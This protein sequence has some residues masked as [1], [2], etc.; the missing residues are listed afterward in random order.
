MSIERQSISST[1]V[2][3]ALV[4]EPKK[5]EDN[6]FAWKRKEAERLRKEQQWNETAKSIE[7]SSLVKGF[8]D[9]LQAPLM[10]ERLFELNPELAKTIFTALDLSKDPI[11][12]KI[13]ERYLGK[14][15]T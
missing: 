12:N 9:P 14:E 11:L 4:A 3:A 7:L 6:I 2:R 5:S 1:M 13:A 8:M 15:V 10:C